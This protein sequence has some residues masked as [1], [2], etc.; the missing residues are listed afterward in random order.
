VSEVY[1]AWTFAKSQT[2]RRPDRVEE[3]KSAEEMTE[4]I[5]QEAM[6]YRRRRLV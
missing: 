1:T 6:K 4:G 3:D 5:C 2:R